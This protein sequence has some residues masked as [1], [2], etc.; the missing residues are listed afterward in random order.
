MVLGPT[1]SQSDIDPFGVSLG[2]SLLIYMF[3]ADAPVKKCVEWI[4]KC[5]E[6]SSVQVNSVQFNSVQLRFNVHIQCKLLYH[7]P[8][9]GT[10]S[11]YRLSCLGL[12]D[13]S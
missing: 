7:T 11:S 6:M 8:V 13:S 5:L 9:M 12:K 1:D 2:Y 4:V 3:D 10:H